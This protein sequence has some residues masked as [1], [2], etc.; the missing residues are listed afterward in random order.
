M[1]KRWTVRW[2]P[3]DGQPEDSEGVVLDEIKTTFRAFP[4]EA[5][6]LAFASKVKG[7]LFGELEV[8]EEYAVSADRVRDDDDLYAYAH[9]GQWWAERGTMRFREGEVER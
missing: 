9:K 2:Q 7:T 5:L 1:D 8:V 6:A 4:T 3:G